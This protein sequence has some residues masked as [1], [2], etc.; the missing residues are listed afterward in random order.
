M[1]PTSSLEDLARAKLNRLKIE[2]FADIERLF[3]LS[4]GEAVR[5]PLVTV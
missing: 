4:S 5:R 3:G 1:T 2:A